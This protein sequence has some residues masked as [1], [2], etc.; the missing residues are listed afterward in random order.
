MIGAALLAGGLGAVARFG[1]SAV[2]DRRFGHG[3]T[4]VVNVAGSFFAG[5]LAGIALAKGVQLIVIGGGL[6]GFTTFSTWMLDA[7]GHGSGAAA[8]RHVAWT[9]GAGLLAALAGLAA[10]AM[11][12]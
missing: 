7:L 3:G 10:G 8:L 9:L 6:G 12:G 1:L 11:A 5:F 2:V 4:V